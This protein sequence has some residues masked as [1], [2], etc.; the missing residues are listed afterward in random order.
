MTRLRS[1]LYVSASNPKSVERGIAAKPDAIIV[2]LEDGVPEADKDA[3]R[4]AVPTVVAH[5]RAADIVVIVRVNGTDTPWFVADIAAAAA[6]APHAV[7]VPKGEPADVQLVRQLLPESIEMW[8]LLDT[9]AAVNDPETILGSG[10]VSAVTIGWGDLCKLRGLALGSEHSEFDII[11]ANVGAAAAAHGVE[12]FDG[13]FV[14]TADDA[15]AACRRSAASG[16]TGRT[17]Y[18]GRHVEPCHRAFDAHRSGA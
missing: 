10:A 18:D 11:R 1:A 15:E 17:L 12:A 14:G 5:V 3:A 13:V 6:V 16:L 4:A 9:E 2:D 7:L 8:A